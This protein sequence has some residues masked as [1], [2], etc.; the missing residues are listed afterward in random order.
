MAPEKQRDLHSKLL[1]IV[2]ESRDKE[3]ISEASRILGIMSSM[4]T[5]V[6]LIGLTGFYSTRVIGHTVYGEA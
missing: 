6:L 1:R 5:R 3:V 2:F 4:Y